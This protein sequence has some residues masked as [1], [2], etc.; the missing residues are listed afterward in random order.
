MPGS[1]A[2]R[3]EVRR[4]KPH[5][6]RA[7]EA[8]VARAEQLARARRL[9]PL[10]QVVMRNDAERRRRGI[11][12]PA[13]S[14]S[15]TLWSSSFASPICSTT[16]AMSS[17]GFPGAACSGNTRRA[18]RP[19]RAR[20]SAGR[21]PPPGAL[22]RA[23]HRLVNLERVAMLVEYGHRSCYPFLG[24]CDGRIS[25]RLG[26]LR[27][28]NAIRSPPPARRR[29]ARAST[30]SVCRRS[31]AEIGAHRARQ[32]AGD[33]D[34]VVPDFLHERLAERVERGLRCAVGRAS[35]N[36]AVD[37]R[38]LMLMI[39]PPPRDRRCGSAARQQ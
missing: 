1:A 34:A 26:R 24:G 15:M 13:L 17:V 39:Q 32:D 20:R 6:D 38:L 36:G 31:A 8:R 10:E 37:D 35:A 9:E 2:S 16:S 4:K 3:R 27:A 23:H 7:P 29:R 21:A 22:R 28:G 19:S 18:G 11:A 12:H 25:T 30:R 33:A 14:R 5:R